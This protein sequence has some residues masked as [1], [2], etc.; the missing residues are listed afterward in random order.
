MIRV[1]VITP[2]RAN[3]RVEHAQ[4]REYLASRERR[5]ELVLGYSDA[6]PIAANRNRI[7]RKFLAD[8]RADYLLMVDSDQAPA[9]NPLDYVENDL[10]IVGFPCPTW[11]V[12]NKEPLIW[13]PEPP[14][15]EG[16]KAQPSVTT[17]CILIARRVLEHP[18]LRHPFA[19]EWDANGL[20]AEGEDVT[21]CQ[22]A[23]VAGFGVWCVMDK[24]VTHIKP[25]ELVTLWQY[26]H[27]IGQFTEE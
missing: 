27:K 15:N 4:F 16:I 20:K 24:P 14:S 13:F 21:F 3:V 26:I 22:R 6:Q 9:F 11:R 19:D 23:I 1:H 18:D 8:E 12:T 2:S 17:G 7:A 10:D 5:F 25:I